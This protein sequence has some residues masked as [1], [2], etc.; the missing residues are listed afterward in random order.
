MIKYKYFSSYIGNSSVAEERYNK[1]IQSFVE[2]ISIEGHV[3]ISVNTISH[4]KDTNNLRT[5]IVYR[6]TI[7]RTVILEKT[8]S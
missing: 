2:S 8:S 5:E 3:F 4:G 7:T 1:A 6:E